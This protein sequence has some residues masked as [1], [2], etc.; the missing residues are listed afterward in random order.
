MKLSRG[1]E[2]IV[3][4]VE[5]YKQS[6]GKKLNLS[7]ITAHRDIITFVRLF[8]ACDFIEERRNER[9]D[10]EKENE[11]IFKSNGKYRKN[12]EDCCFALWT[13]RKKCDFKRE[14]Q[15]AATNER[16]KRQNA[17]VVIS[18]LFAFAKHQNRCQ[19]ARN[20]TK[21]RKNKLQKWIDVDM[22]V[23]C[24]FFLSALR[25]FLVYLFSVA[26]NTAH[27]SS[28]SIVKMLIHC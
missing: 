12:A 15:N 5:L 23:V 19:C 11:R 2:I 21:S 7:H 10:R 22:S 8:N 25:N 14:S 18:K 26:L 9:T 6:S 20:R 16:E 17:F 27:S 24:F 4:Y 28:N 3:E 13:R 1:W